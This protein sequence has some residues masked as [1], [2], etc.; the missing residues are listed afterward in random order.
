MA[1]KQQ[2]LAASLPHVLY[3]LAQPNCVDGSGQIIGESQLTAAGATCATGQ[4]EFKAINDIHIGVVTSSLGD[5]GGGTLCT[6]G[7][8]TSFSQPDGG[9]LPVPPDV[10]DMGRLVGSLTRGAQALQGDS[11][12]VQDGVVKLDTKGFLAWGS[13]DALVSPTVAELS[14]ATSAFKDMVVATAYG[15]P[16]VLVRKKRNMRSIKNVLTPTTPYLRNR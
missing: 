15:I 10:N 6:P 2:V 4:L 13:S 12:I 14:S 8:T 1:D 5:H 3:Q 9:L 16:I 11:T 7:A